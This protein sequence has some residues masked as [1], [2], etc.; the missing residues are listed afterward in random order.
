MQTFE[1]SSQRSP[2]YTR[3]GMVGASQP[4]AVA[5]G[6]ELLRK[7]GNAADAAVAAAAALNV[8][9]PFSTGLG[10]DCFAL[11]YSAQTGRISA[12]N[13]SGR[14]PGALT[15]ER[16]RSEGFSAGLPPRHPYT[17]TVPGACAGWSDLIERHGK[18]SLREVLQPAIQLAEEGFPVAPLTAD[19]WADLAQEALKPELGGQELTIEGRAP[20]AGEVFRNPGLAEALTRIAEGG[21]Q[22]FYTG[23]L[24]RLIVQAVRAAEGC[25]DESDLAAHQTT[26]ETPI[27]TSYRGVNIW[28]CPPNG[29]G[30]AALLALNLLEGFDLPD[31]PP[32]SPERLHLQIEAMRLAF[33]DA[34]AFVADPAYS[35]IPL[36][37]LLSKDYASHRRSLIDPNRT[38]LQHPH[39]APQAAS[40]TVYLS[41]V[42]GQGNAC[43]F[44]NSLY[45]GFGTGIVPAGCGFAL[46]NRGHNFSLDPDSPNALAPGKRPYHTII[47]AMATLPASKPLPEDEGAEQL[48]ACFGV[49]GGFMQPQGHMQVTCALIDDR[50]DPQSALDRPRFCILDGRSGGSVALE[51]GL[52]VQAMSQLAEMGH[53]I[54]PVSGSRRFVFGRGQIIQR[55]P[56]SGVLCGGSDPRADG[57]VMTL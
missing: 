56:H 51:E 33:A 44:I 50:L 17:V 29:Q 5:T 49:M 16:V 14:A 45:M 3:G 9:E 15:L 34:H 8:C 37:G 55:D 26:W 36:E 21:K 54:V 20:R 24:A 2:V 32:L 4:L 40:D 13:G 41:V 18:L 7:G 6:L 12:M 35:S 42:D 52:P 30:L 27:H 11:F 23:E 47:P 19:N 31:L 25:L 46:Q 57:C 53:P 1:F 38:S 28:E 48:F 10:G 43:S 39:G 22:A